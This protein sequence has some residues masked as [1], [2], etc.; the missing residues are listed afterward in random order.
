MEIVAAKE[1]AL[2]ELLA[3]LADLRAGPASSRLDEAR[4]GK[5]EAG[6]EALRIYLD[7]IERS[8]RR[9]NLSLN[10]VTAENRLLRNSVRRL[11]SGV[12]GDGGFDLGPLETDIPWRVIA[13]YQRV[14]RF[15][16]A[17]I[18]EAAGATFDRLGRIRRPRT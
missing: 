16:P 3:E 15:V 4:L 2:R 11:Q 12:A 7:D 13:A 10:A 1:K 8:L 18:L 9:S 17:R 6:V 14:R 5:L